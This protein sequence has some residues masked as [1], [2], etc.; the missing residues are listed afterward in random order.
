[1][2]EFTC[3]PI[4]YHHQVAMFALT[5]AGKEFRLNELP[6]E[7]AAGV[8]PACTYDEPKMNGYLEIC[9]WALKLNDDDRDFLK[10]L[11]EFC[12]NNI[13]RHTNVLLHSY[14]SDNIDESQKYELAVFSQLL[15][16]E[17]K[18]KGLNDKN[19]TLY[20]ITLIPALFSLLSCY[21]F[22]YFKQLTSFYKQNF[23]SPKSLAA[24]SRIQN[25]KKTNLTPNLEK[26]AFDKL[27][28]ITRRSYEQFS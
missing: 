6:V 21:P 26:D 4:N 3:L 14:L 18:L 28:A 13:S 1:M 22:H 15:K 27:S 16:L 7:S 23:N 25:Y 5:Y 12:N 20:T 2:S 9:A 17:H 19:D 8:Q 11:S 24:I 10:S